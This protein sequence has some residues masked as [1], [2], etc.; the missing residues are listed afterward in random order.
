MTTKSY[1]PPDLD[2]YKDIPRIEVVKTQDPVVIKNTAVTGSDFEQL[3]EDILLSL[4]PRISD[5][6]LELILREK[7]VLSDRGSSEDSAY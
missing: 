6:I 4:E 1:S 3:K 5:L 2:L 7:K